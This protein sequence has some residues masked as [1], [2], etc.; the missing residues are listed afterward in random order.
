MKKIL[1]LL[2]LTTITLA[3][4][5]AQAMEVESRKARVYAL[6]EAMANSLKKKQK[7]NAPKII[8]DINEQRKGL[9]A[10][11]HLNLLNQLNVTHSLGF[12]NQI[13]KLNGINELSDL[14]V[15][16]PSV[17]IS[18]LSLIEDP[19]HNDDADSDQLTGETKDPNLYIGDRIQSAHAPSFVS[20]RT[21]LYGIM[22]STIIMVAYKLYSTSDNGADIEKKSFEDAENHDAEFQPGHTDVV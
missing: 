9:D 7:K 6:Q 21:L 16:L 12:E 8:R 19:D 4:E 2:M 3:T 13:K 15:V 20:K 10:Q 22:L 18:D 5:M 14:V 1:I 17:T 11:E